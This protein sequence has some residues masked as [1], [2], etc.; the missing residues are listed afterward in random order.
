MSKK[1]LIGVTKSTNL[2]PYKSTSVKVLKSSSRYASI[3]V[4]HYSLLQYMHPNMKQRPAP[5]IDNLSKATTILK[6]Q[7]KLLLREIAN[8]TNTSALFLCCV[9][10]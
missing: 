2:L 3:Y 4:N 5:N 1:V 8:V 9:L 6:L 7:L 10:G